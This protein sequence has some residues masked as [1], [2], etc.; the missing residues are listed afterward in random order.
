MLWILIHTEFWKYLE[1][2]PPYV[3]RTV[4]NADFAEGVHWGADRGQ[5]YRVDVSRQKRE[6]GHV[7]LLRQRVGTYHF[8]PVLD[9]P[10]ENDEDDYK[11]LKSIKQVK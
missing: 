2:S 9:V 10:L 3:E 6:A 4:Q 8:C 1:L 11:A 5:I 7:S